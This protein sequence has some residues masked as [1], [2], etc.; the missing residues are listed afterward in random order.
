V[1][2]GAFV[3]FVRAAAATPRASKAEL[4]LA[5]LVDALPGGASYLARQ[6]LLQ[7]TA[8]DAAASAAGFRTRAELVPL[9]VQRYVDAHPRSSA[10]SVMGGEIASRVVAR[11]ARRGPLAGKVAVVTGASSGIG[12][13]ISVALAE[14]GCDVVLAAR[15]VE[16]LEETR[17]LLS[18]RAPLA[19]ALAVQTDVTQLASVRDLVARTEAEIG[20]IDILVNNAGVLG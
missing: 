12:R 7:C 10:L 8:F 15:N 11:A 9:A 14:A 16:R 19:R 6:P 13:G 17:A 3:E 1:S 20:E 4:S 18:E 5:A 2:W